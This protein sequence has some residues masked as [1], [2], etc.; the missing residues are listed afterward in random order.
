MTQPEEFYLSFPENEDDLYVAYQR[1]ANLVTYIKLGG[2]KTD[3]HS[4]SM[5]FGMR[6]FT[7]HATLYNAVIE[8]V[9]VEHNVASQWRISIPDYWRSSRCGSYEAKRFW[10]PIDF[11]HELYEFV[12]D[13]AEAS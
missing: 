2:R 10:Q 4:F 8:C 6:D 5:S 12:D 1:Y 7:F 3:V 9:N 11:V 13:Y